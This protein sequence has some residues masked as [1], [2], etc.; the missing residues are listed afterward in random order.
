MY[1]NY[2]KEIANS[3]GVDAVV[4]GH[5]HAFCLEENEKSFY[6][7]LGARENLRFCYALWDLNE[8]KPTVHFVN[9]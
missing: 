7:N 4:M 9:I 1:K 5:N 2:A 6:L 3:L 8:R